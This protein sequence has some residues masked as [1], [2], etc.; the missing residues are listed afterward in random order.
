M[1]VT[2]NHELL[3]I[4]YSMICTSVRLAQPADQVVQAVQNDRGT[5]S[6]KMDRVL[7]YVRTY[8]VSRGIPP[9][10]QQIADNLGVS[11]TTVTWYLRELEKRGYL[12]LIKGARRAIVLAQAEPVPV[13]EP[14]GP[15]PPEMPLVADRFVVEYLPEVFARYWAPSADFFMRVVG[16]M[17]LPGF[18]DGELVGIQK[19]VGTQNKDDPPR[20]RVAVVRVDGEVKFRVFRRRTKRFLKLATLD[21]RR[22]VNANERVDIAEHD[23]RIEGF[24]VHTFM[25]LDIGE[26]DYLEPPPAK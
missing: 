1:R 5:L 8:L 21:A 25:A 15:I 12:T 11:V 10:R 18:R 22:N 24:V 19:L 2:P 17:D 9:T 23:V 14:R 26:L 6:E 13:V 3:D 7:T 16:G 20:G 4:F